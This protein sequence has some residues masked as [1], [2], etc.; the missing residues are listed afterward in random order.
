VT[1]YR[2]TLNIEATDVLDAVAKIHSAA[3]DAGLK[4]GSLEVEEY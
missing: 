4:L 3:Y 1:Q 2:V